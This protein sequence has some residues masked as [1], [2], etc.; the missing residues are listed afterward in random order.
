M[1]PEQF[2]DRQ[3]LVV[4]PQPYNPDAPGTAVQ[5]DGHALSL[6]M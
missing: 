2:R 1:T 5:Y 6:K 4:H 3:S